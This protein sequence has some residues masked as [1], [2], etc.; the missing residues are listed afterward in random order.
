M[1]GEASIMLGR[2]GGK[3][4]AAPVLSASGW[5]MVVFVPSYLARTKPAILWLLRVS[6]L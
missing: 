1:Q 5:F 3:D 6:G 4:A 2:P